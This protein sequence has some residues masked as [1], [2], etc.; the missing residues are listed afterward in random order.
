MNT[1]LASRAPRAT[2]TIPFDFVLSRASL[3]LLG[4]MILLLPVGCL[5]ALPGKPDPADRY[6]RPHSV[7]DFDVLYRQRCSGCHGSDGRLGPAPPLNDPLF[8]A[9]CSDSDMKH[10]I[11]HGRSG[12]PMP[13]FAQQQG[14]PL[15]DKQID[16]LIA[17]IRA[18]WGT[19]SSTFEQ[20][21]P[22][23]SIE[24]SAE[25]DA[26][27]GD[28]SVGLR[29]FAMYCAECHGMEGHGGD[30]AGAL[31]DEAFLATISNQALRRIVITGRP[32]LG[33]PNFR[34]M[35][36]SSSQ[37]T[38]LSSKN[39]ADLVALMGMWRDSLVHLTKAENERGSAH[40][41]TH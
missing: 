37:S 41:P 35:G 8:L 21:L 23:Y 16:A 26:Q 14:G 7:L 25:N 4:L 12:T 15:T 3:Q 9:I 39:I 17:G 30:A 20:P 38:P 36:E 33:M 10:T 22:E 6:Q 32:D 13:S 34:E 18:T 2:P 11:V 40:E 24:K 1:S 28:A 29:N 19:A 31:K 27:V 5:D